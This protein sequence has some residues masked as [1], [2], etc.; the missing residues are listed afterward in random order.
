MRIPLNKL[1]ID[2]LIL[3]ILT[4]IGLRQSMPVKKKIEINFTSWASRKVLSAPKLCTLFTFHT[5][6]LTINF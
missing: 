5:V 2:F 3:L 6:T 4:T 1:V